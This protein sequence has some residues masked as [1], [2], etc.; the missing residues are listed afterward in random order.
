MG[1][2]RHVASIIVAFS[3]PED[4]RN[5]KGILVR[6]GFDVAAVCTSGSQTLSAAEGLSGGIVV[7]GY[8]FEDMM[9]DEL[10]QCLPGI[11]DMLLISSPSRWSGQSVNN[12]LCLHMPLKVHDLVSTLEMMIQ[13]QRRFRKKAREKP[14]ERSREEQNTIEE[15]KTLLME[16]NN[17]TESEAHRYIQKCSMDSG[18]NLV[19][20]AQMVISLIHV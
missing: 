6:N 8:R 19:E 20:T 2:V 7:S 11:Y 17:M 10:R 13:S 3:R 5:I 4:G 12:V 14:R 15:A 9:Y 18:T 16:R 1:E